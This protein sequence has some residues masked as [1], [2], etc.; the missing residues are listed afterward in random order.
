MTRDDEIRRVE[1]GFHDLADFALDS[2]SNLRIVEK[3]KALQSQVQQ[4]YP[5]VL[6]PSA[7]PV[8]PAPPIVKEPDAGFVEADGFIRVTDSTR[9]G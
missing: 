4:L 8:P 2:W 7:P 1:Q 5:P 6:V 9:W 3:I